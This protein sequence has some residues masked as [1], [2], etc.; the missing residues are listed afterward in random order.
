MIK[1]V[2]ERCSKAI[3]PKAV[4]LCTDS[5]ELKFLAEKWGYKVLLTSSE[6]SSG[7]ERIASVVDELIAIAWA[8]KYSDKKLF[9]S[10]KYNSST[11]IVNVQ[12]DQPFLNPD[13]LNRLCNINIFNDSEVDVIT[14]IYKLR[15]D[16][17]HNPNNV[18]VV[19]SKDSEAIYFS[20]SAL[21]Y[22]RGLEQDKWHTV[23]DYWGHV[24]IYSFKARVLSLWSE[25][26]T[27]KLEKLENLEQLRLIDAKFKIKTFKVD[28]E[29]FSIDTQEQLVEAREIANSLE[30]I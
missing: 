22:V 26:P 5:D 12:A 20:R 3:G 29:A 28:D 18:K 17:I 6:C 23:N 2:L 19:I 30:R 7:S 14:P 1:R 21:P 16:K 25:L 9:K 15:Q 11:I 4:V 8:D 10:S 13:L 27:S 24:G